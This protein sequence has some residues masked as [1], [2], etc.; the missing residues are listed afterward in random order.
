MSTPTTPSITNGSKD[1]ISPQA[2]N[3][4]EQ[5]PPPPPPYNESDYDF[6]YESDCE[7]STPDV[8]L[9]INANQVVRGSHNLIP[10][11]DIPMAHATRISAMLLSAFTQNSKVDSQNVLAPGRPLKV[12]LNINCGIHIIGDRNVIGNIGITPKIAQ[13]PVGQGVQTTENSAVDRGKRRLADGGEH[14]AS[15]RLKTTDT[16]LHL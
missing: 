12:H 7:G 15:K 2:V 5:Q 10:I 8:Q 9:S 4:N 1:Y 6:N 13:R 14:E 3:N 16:A 11:N